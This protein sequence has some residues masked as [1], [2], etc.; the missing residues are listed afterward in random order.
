MLCLFLLLWVTA[1]DVARKRSAPS[2]SWA[3][4]GKQ[5]RNSVFSLLM[6][7]YQNVLSDF[8]HPYPQCCFS[9]S[10]GITDGRPESAVWSCSP[11]CRSNAA[12]SSTVTSLQY[13]QSSP[14]LNTFTYSFVK[15]KNKNNSVTYTQK[16]FCYIYLWHA[17]VV[18]IRK[19]KRRKWV[20][21]AFGTV[22]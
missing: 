16:Y 6:Q 20:L 18:D 21:K 9:L 22:L 1:R 13:L 19:I 5:Q 4:A 12:F 3:A 2:T 8:F 10:Q 17:L 7:S 15:V 11:S 14:L